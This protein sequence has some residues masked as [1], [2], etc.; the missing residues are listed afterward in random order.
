[1]SYGGD[2]PDAYR[3]LRGYAARVLKGE[4]PAELPVQQV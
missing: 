2:N 1:M 3:L 4:N